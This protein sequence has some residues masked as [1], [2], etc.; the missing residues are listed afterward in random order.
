MTPPTSNSKAWLK[1]N[2]Y[3]FILTISALY[4]ERALVEMYI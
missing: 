4:V 1:V 2:S 3:Q